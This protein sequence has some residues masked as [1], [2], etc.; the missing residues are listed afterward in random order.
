MKELI[1][2]IV[3]LLCIVVFP[4]VYLCAEGTKQVMPNTNSKGQLCINRSRN[5]FAFY[6]AEPEFKLNISI[7]STS[8]TIRF[9][10]GQDLGNKS[11]ALFF[12]I[13]GP[14]GNI[15]YAESQVPASGQ[16]FIAS[17]TQ[18]VAGPF[19]GGYDY[20]ELIPSD[21][22]DYTLEFYYQPSYTDN[23]RHL[24]EFFDITV[25]D[26]SQKAVNGRVWSKAWQFWSGSDNNS[27]I[28]QFYGKMMI[29][30]DDSIVTQVDCNGFRGGTFSISSNMTGCDSTDDLNSDRKSKVGFHTNPQYK[31]FLNNPDSILFPTQ[32]LNSGI[33]L[34]VT[35]NTSCTSGGADFGIKVV[36]DG[37]IRLLIQVNPL[38]GIDPEDVQLIANVEA[39]PANGNEYNIIHWD[40]NDSYGR[41]VSNAT[42]LSFSLTNL[43]GMTH[44]PIHD[45]E[46]ND[47]GYKVSQIRPAGGQLR[48]YWDDTNIGGT[49][50]ATNGCISTINTGCHTWNNGNNNTI[51]SWWYVSWDETIPVTFVTQKAP[52]TLILSGNNVHCAGTGTLAF[53]VAADP[54]S[55]SYNW[56][57]SGTGVTISGTG[58][59]VTLNFGADATPGTLSVNGINN[60]C[61]N[62]PTRSVAIIFEPLPEVTLPTI[63]EMCYTAPG[64]KLTGGQ[65]EGGTYYVDGIKAD[66]L[67]P[68][69]EPEGLHT[70]VY[71]YTAPAGCSNSDTTGI[72]LRT[73]A[74]CQ[75]NV[76]FP[77]AFTPGNDAVNNTFRP[78]VY[79]ISSFTMY[80]FD[81]WG[82]LIYSTDN[83]DTGWDGNYKGE[84]CPA[85]TYSYSVTYG[86]SLRSD[87]K[88]TRRGTFVLIR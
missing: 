82:Q 12:R 68:Y 47:Y 41:P 49:S 16:G 87:D 73:G 7:A 83:A 22:G 75:G 43:S 74:D 17:Y 27:D 50:N 69:K 67:F 2:S 29:L 20:L 1:R 85:G 13:T 48:I 77:N 80:V 63:P 79:S 15:V 61:G 59:T 72:L 81:R 65:P 32:K 8:E 86:P 38:P 78:V 42:S 60:S 55:T 36:K 19:A 39:N 26:A 56:S 64:F 52:S 66:S 37:S 6:G 54:N 4:T 10:F 45:I 34:P 57:Y 88:K 18:A 31:I 40:G 5:T 51:N 28:D 44:L 23:T 71:A 62:G 35:V 3:A 14:S 25:T 21:L 58:T 24:L 33:L 9:G 11:I 84:A 70:I 46:N 76:Y 53:S 30:S